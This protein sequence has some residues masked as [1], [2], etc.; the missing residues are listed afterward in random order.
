ML[1]RSPLDDE[2]KR[3]CAMICPMADPVVQRFL[4]R[5][6]LPRRA[7][8]QAIVE[9][10]R[11]VPYGRPEP[12]TPEGLVD[13]WTGTCSTKHALLARCLDELVPASEP[14]LVH[15][16]Y[17][18]TRDAAERLFGPAAAAV[19]PPEGLTDVHTYLIATLGERDVVLDVTFPGP[20]W[21]GSSD[22]PVAAAEGEDFPPGPEPAATK[23]ALVDAHCDPA[24][25]EPFIA[26]LSRYA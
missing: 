20:E 12:R 11:A 1:S 2:R 17:R 15:R 10:L 24:V 16:V 22:M 7:E 8:P 3:R 4:Q 18:V 23:A 19:V 25:R 13:Q 5:A 21:D 9:A 14:R 26:A 6:G